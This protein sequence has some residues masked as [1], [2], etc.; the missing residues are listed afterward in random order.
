MIGEFTLEAKVSQLMGNQH[1]KRDAAV[2]VN[3][4]VAG[5]IVGEE[6]K[7]ECKPNIGAILVICKRL[8]GFPAVDQS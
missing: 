2:E 5:F 1:A 8:L 7:C 4:C 6:L 3:S